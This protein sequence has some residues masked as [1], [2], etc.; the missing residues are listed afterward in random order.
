MPPFYFNYNKKRALLSLCCSHP[1]EQL[2]APNTYLY[3][4]KKHHLPLPSRWGRKGTSSS[5]QPIEVT[6]RAD[7]HAHA[8]ARVPSSPP[9]L[10]NGQDPCTPSSAASPPMDQLHMLQ[11]STAHGARSSTNAARVNSIKQHVV[12]APSSASTRRQREGCVEKPP[13]PLTRRPHGSLRGCANPFAGDSETRPIGTP[14]T[15]A[16]AFKDW[17]RWY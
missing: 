10:T 6:G 15:L 7:L 16:G 3:Q 9:S 8:S 13:L 11:Q 1:D 4:Y 17:S 14:R 5:S 2:N 12:Q